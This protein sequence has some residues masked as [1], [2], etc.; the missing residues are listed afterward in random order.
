MRKRAFTLIELIFVI[1]IMGILSKYGIE[2]LFQ[3]YKNFIFSKTNN[4]LQSES[5]AAVETIAARLQYRIKDSI[6]AKKTATDFTALASSTYGDTATVLEWISYDI[7]GQRGDGTQT[8]PLWSGII[9][10]K[11]ADTN[12]TSLVSPATDTTKISTMIVALGGSGISDAALYS[13]GSDS[14]INASYGWSGA[15]ANQSGAMH[16]INSVGGE[17]TQF[18]S[19]VGGNFIGADIYEYY[20]LAWTA[21]A[22]V[23]NPN[24]GELRLY[25]DYQPWLGE[26]YSDNGV[27]NH[28]IMNNVETFRFKGVGSIVKIQVCVNTDLVEEYSLCKEKTVF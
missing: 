15:L 3:A 28:L 11:H 12:T 18:Q 2:L 24:N 25:Y 5:E 9:D 7:D 4:A 10:L 26:K 6:I 13:I 20:Q 16:R 1:V 27:K 8:A 19:G 22:V 23:H 21:Y 17:P 14:D